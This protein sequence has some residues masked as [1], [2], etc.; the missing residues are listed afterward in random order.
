M[1]MQLECPSGTSASITNL[2]GGK[3]RYV[4]V[5]SSPH[6]E[7]DLRDCPVGN[8]IH[9]STGMKHQ[10]ET[11]YIGTD[12]F[13]FVR[14]Y[15]SDRNGWTHNYQA[16]L[17]DVDS[18]LGANVDGRG[19]KPLLGASSNAP[20]CFRYVVNASNALL[21]SKS[22]GRI[23]RFDATTGL[24]ASPDVKDGVTKLLDSGGT[25]IGWDVYDSSEDNFKRF[26]S[27]GRL[28]TVTH[29]G[30]RTELLSYSDASTPASIAPYPGLL[31]TVSSS[32]GHKLSLSYDSGGRLTSL[33][34]PGGNQILYS[35]DGASSIVG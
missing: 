30:G 22:N 24:P 12:G 29:R 34:D 17:T 23:L 32:N 25:V 26:D 20:Y 16:A 18:M 11:D 19:C 27:A 8:P 2:G 35:Y 21:V 9:L 14:A 15:R 3:R 7:P 5:E 1:F 28:L 33:K 4:C 31:V 6:P 13:K 10:V